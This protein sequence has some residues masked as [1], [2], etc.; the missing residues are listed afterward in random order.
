MQNIDR[1][2]Y[3]VIE[4]TKCNNPKLIITISSSIAIPCMA[5]FLVTDTVESYSCS[6]QIQF[7]SFKNFVVV[8]NRKSLSCVQMRFD[9]I[10]LSEDKSSKSNDC[11]TLNVLLFIE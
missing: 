11:S 6:F 8:Y 9:T 10:D 4:H 7:S 5:L 3:I 2:T 1:S